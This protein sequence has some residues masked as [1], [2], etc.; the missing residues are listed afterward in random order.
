MPSDNDLEQKRE[1]IIPPSSTAPVPTKKTDV[2]LFIKNLSLQQRLLILT[3]LFVVLSFV[4]IA[5]VVYPVIKEINYL[6]QQ[7]TLYK[8]E[9][10]RKYQERFNVRKTIDD[11]EEAKKLL[12]QIEVSF[13]PKD[14]EIK[15]VEFLERTADKYSLQQ[16]T[17]NL[18]PKTKRGFLTQLDIALTLEGK[19]LNTLKYL[20]ELEKQNIYINFTEILI[21][22]QN[23]EIITTRLKGTVWKLN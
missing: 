12:P 14:G 1:E 15:F 23:P 13:I 4:G 3:G 10:E 21:T 17:I 20:D 7:V 18:D 2:L 11:L 22:A 5:F 19:F 9:L 8:S 6:N 16:K